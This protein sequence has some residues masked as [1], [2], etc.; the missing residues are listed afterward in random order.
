M[1]VAVLGAGPSGT[2]AAWAALQSGCSVEIFSNTFVQQKSYGVF[3]LHD[4]CDLPV[5][6]QPVM[7]Q[8]I[9]NK[10]MDAE[11]AAKAYGKF[12]YQKEDE[13]WGILFALKEKELLGYDPD[14]VMSLLALYL[15]SVQRNTQEFNSLCDVENVLNDFDRVVCTVPASAI[16]PNEQ[17][18]YKAAYAVFGDN[19]HFATN[20]FIDNVNASL[21]WYRLSHLFGRFVVEYVD[22][23]PQSVKIK[24][25]V[26]GHEVKVS[27]S[28]ILFTGRYG[29]WNRRIRAENVY[30]DTLKF[31]GE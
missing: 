20:F 27:N 16:F 10:N 19:K 22:P 2:L 14:E 9:G 25:V 8:V 26:G 7:Q 23:M 3:F 24:K 1:K 15:E 12:V 28:A 17:W 6:G 18:P 21:G 30:Q 13:G 11:T 4:N 29:A 31:L 5:V